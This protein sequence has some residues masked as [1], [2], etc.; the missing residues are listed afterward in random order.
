MMMVARAVTEICSACMPPRLP[1]TFSTA[2]PTLYPVCF[3][4]EEV[5]A[6]LY[7]CTSPDT[8]KYLFIPLPATEVGG[9]LRLSRL[10]PS[11]AMLTH[12]VS[13]ELGSDFSF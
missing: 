4:A 13:S 3:S 2:L 9:I 10:R 1:Q 12:A 6:L 8:A 11:H 7:L 5:L